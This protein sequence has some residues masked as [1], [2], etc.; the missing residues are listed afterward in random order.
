MPGKLGRDEINQLAGYLLLDYR[1]ELGI[2]Q[3]GL[4]LSR[5]GAMITWTVTEFLRLLGA[6]EPLTRRR[7]RLH[8]H[9]AACRTTM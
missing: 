9:L 8:R 7:E 2:N 5:Q 6:D 3:V 4:Y 1:D